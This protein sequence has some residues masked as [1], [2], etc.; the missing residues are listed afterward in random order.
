MISLPYGQKSYQ[1]LLPH[2]N[3][4]F[5]RGSPKSIAT[6]LHFGEHPKTQ[7]LNLNCNDSPERRT[8]VGLVAL[9]GLVRRDPK[10]LRKGSA[11]VRQ[12][13]RIDC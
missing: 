8:I 10:P 4:R 5:L 12:Q 1:S 2:P 3:Q 6:A 13:D 9:G 7:P 11:R